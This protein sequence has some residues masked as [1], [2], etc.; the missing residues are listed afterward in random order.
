MSGSPTGS[1]SIAASS[2][3]PL[4]FIDQLPRLR[5]A[6]FKPQVGEFVL[7]RRQ[8]PWQQIGR[9]RRNHAERQPSY[10]KPAAMPREIDQI[11]R[12]REHVLAA[13]RDL[14][15]H[16]GQQHLARTAFDHGYPK[17]ALKIADLHR[18]RR[19]RDRAG[20]RR[21]AEMAVFGERREIAKLPERNHSA[22][23]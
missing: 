10:Q 13:A 17:R 22:I 7:Q 19:L 23:R 12:G 20:F 1:A 3:P 11:T 9:E 5:L 21:A 8:N 4:D 16:F 2:A 14:A 15:A 18:Q 6:Q